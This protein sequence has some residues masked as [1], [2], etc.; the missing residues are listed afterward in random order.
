M[1]VPQD[2]LNELFRE[3]ELAKGLLEHLAE[4]AA[5][6][7]IGPGVSSAEVTDGLHLLGAY[8]L[9]H[10]RRFDRDF[11]PEARPVAN[12]KCYE[13]LDR[14]AEDRATEGATIASVL[15]SS[16]LADDGTPATRREFARQ[17]DALVE[18]DRER[19]LYETDYPLAC[20]LSILPEET[21][22]EIL[23]RFADTQEE[24]R[25]LEEHIQ[26]YIASPSATSSE[27][28]VPLACAHAG[29]PAKVDIVLAA[30]TEGALTLNL[31][32][33]WKVVLRPTRVAGSGDIEFSVKGCCPEH[34]SEREH[35]FETSR[36]LRTW[37]DDGGRP[38]P[39]AIICEES[40]AADCEGKASKA[41]A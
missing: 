21:A 38:A 6:L 13:H 19:I 35:V 34:V 23:Q 37:A 18:A 29:C 2:P 7:R 10:A 15:R 28:H 1:A 9:L 12:P 4:L 27:R 30:G 39:A 40:R 24:L 8:R 25:D 16:H 33:G 3:N 17:I 5:K 22:A 20:L 31:A 41:T 26:R 36:A 32:S 14:I 11:Q